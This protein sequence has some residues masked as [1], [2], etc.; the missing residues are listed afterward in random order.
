MQPPQIPREA[1]EA[2]EI[3]T[4][5]FG[6]GAGLWCFGRVSP[7]LAGRLQPGSAHFQRSSAVDRECL[8]LSSKT[9]K[10]KRWDQALRLTTE[11]RTASMPRRAGSILQ[12]R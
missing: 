11:F 5:Q 8:V 7:D 12:R 10:I 2:P 6:R 9:T 1:A 4:T 3:T